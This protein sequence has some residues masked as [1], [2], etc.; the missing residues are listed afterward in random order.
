M[1]LFDAGSS[2]TRMSVYE[3]NA[4]YIP[5]TKNDLNITQIGYCVTDGN[6]TWLHSCHSGFEK[7]YL[8]F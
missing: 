2:G 6:L 4:D 8:L 1:I 5:N 7:N 3:W